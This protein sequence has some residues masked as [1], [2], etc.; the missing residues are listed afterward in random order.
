MSGYD[1]AELKAI[2]LSFAA[3]EIKSLIIILHKR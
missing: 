2:I 3:H 1:I